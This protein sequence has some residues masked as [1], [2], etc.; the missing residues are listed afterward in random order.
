MGNVF[1]RGRDMLLVI[2]LLKEKYEEFF[3]A[4]KLLYFTIFTMYTKYRYMVIIYSNVHT[5]THKRV[6]SSVCVYNEAI[7]LLV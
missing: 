2:K 3:N 1:Y 4:R 7:S 5:Y 6:Y